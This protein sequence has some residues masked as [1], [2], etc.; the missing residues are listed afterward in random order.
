M[1]CPEFVAHS[2]A[3][4]TAAHVAHLMSR[5]Y[6]EHV[7]LGDFYDALLDLVDKYAEIHMGLNAAILKIPSATPPEMSPVALLTDYLI[8][9]RKEQKSDRE[10][11]ALMNVLAEI[12]EL[13]AQTLY[14]LRFLK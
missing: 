14:K 4:R 5:S 10:S 1:S 9:V 7:A 8:A 2:F 11:Q 3:V 6:A 12:E 13:T